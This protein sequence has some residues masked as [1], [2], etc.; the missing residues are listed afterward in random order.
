MIRQSARTGL[1]CSTSR[2]QRE[3]IQAHGH[4]GSNQNCTSSR[5]FDGAVTLAG[6]RRPDWRIPAIPALVS[7]DA[8][9]PQLCE[10]AGAEVVEQAG[11]GAV[12]PDL[13][14]AGRTEQHAG[15]SRGGGRERQR[16]R[17]RGGG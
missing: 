15:E 7:P 9:T 13:L 5:S 3:V 14:R 8:D 1:T 2:I 16:P 10:V 6:N 12:G 17:R 4:S 11:G